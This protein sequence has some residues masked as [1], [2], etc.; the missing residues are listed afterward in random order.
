LVK[1]HHLGEPMR[2]DGRAKVFQETF[3]PGLA[4]ICWKQEE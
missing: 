3:P 4:R 1:V 2:A